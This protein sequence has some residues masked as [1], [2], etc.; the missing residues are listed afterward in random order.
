MPRKPNTTAKRYND[1]FPTAL[2]RLMAERKTTQDVLAQ[3]LGVKNRQSVT[4]YINGNT[5]PNSDKIVALAEFFG[6]S[7]DY[8]LGLSD[9]KTDNTELIGVCE[10]TGLSD[11]TEELR[12][13]VEIIK[14]ALAVIVHALARI[15]RR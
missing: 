4:G 1:P 14:E 8:L 13:E 10:H 3:V 2:R 7:A 5:L 15:R 9:I 6:V 11:E 12:T